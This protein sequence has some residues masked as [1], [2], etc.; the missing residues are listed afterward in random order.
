MVFLNICFLCKNY[1]VHNINIKAR[2]RNDS[3]NDSKNESIPNIED[4]G[5]KL[6]KLL[7]KNKE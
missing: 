4:K 6:N 2:L 1:A 7:Q 3:K 5:K